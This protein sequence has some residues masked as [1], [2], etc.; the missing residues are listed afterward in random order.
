MA[1]EKDRG[2]YALIL[3]KRMI[4]LQEGFFLSA[5]KC[6]S[7]QKDLTFFERNSRGG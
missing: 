5:T 2:K 6:F 7:E 4:A 1:V 3:M